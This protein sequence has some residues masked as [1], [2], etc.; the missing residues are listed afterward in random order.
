LLLWADLAPSTTTESVT[1]KIEAVNALIRGWCQY[2]SITSNPSEAFRRLEVDIFGKMV[3][4]LGHKY[5]IGIP[6]VLQKILM[7]TQ[8]EKPLEQKAKH[9]TCQQSI[10]PSDGP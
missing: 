9:L 8:K 1:A 2:Y 4:W 7:T 3:H 10:R 6:K 5:K